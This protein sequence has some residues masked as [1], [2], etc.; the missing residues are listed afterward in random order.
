MGTLSLILVVVHV[1]VLQVS[2][3]RRIRCG[4]VA[5]TNGATDSSEVLKLRKRK[6]ALS[7]YIM[8][9]L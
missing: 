6:R 8:K 5:A 9:T 4:G 7:M 2:D 3:L 1:D